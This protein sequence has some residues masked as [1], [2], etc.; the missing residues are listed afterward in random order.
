MQGVT[1]ITDDN[2]DAEVLQSS[3]PVAVDFWAPWCGPCRMLGPIMEQVAEEIGD[4]AKICKLDVDDN[5]SIAAKYG[6][7]S[8]PTVIIF[9][10]GQIV[11]QFTGV[12]QRQ[13]IIEMLKNAV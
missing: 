3:I 1:I 7:M 9:K 10:N 11:N 6:I 8:I 2:F 13:A 4:S 12:R 5:K